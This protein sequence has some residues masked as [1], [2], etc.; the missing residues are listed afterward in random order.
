MDIDAI[1]EDR[2]K[3][4]EKIEKTVPGLFIK[5]TWRNKFGNSHRQTRVNRVGREGGLE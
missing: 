1:H 2:K 3:K 5:E 4:K